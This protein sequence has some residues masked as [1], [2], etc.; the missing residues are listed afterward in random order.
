M[1]EDCKWICFEIM[2]W[3][4]AIF[5]QPADFSWQPGVTPMSNFLHLLIGEVQSF[6]REDVSYPCGISIRR[7][8][9]PIM[10][11]PRMLDTSSKWSQDPVLTISYWILLDPA[12]VVYF[13]V[14]FGLKWWL[15]PVT[16]ENQKDG[17]LMKFAM[18]VHNA[19]LC[20]L[21][22]AMFAGAGYEAYLRSQ[23]C[24]PYK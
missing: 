1:S 12:Q 8:T 10:P 24:R 7:A 17:A 15:G 22:A 21:S 19:F 3:V 23:V 18:C 13:T 6:I 20:L 2:S 5:I 14:I 11:H 16:K 4:D 9:C